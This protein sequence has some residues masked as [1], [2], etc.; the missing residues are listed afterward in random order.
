MDACLGYTAVLGAE[1]FELMGELQ[2]ELR[3]DQ[4][5]RALDG[6]ERMDTKRQLEDSLCDAQ[7]RLL[8]LRLGLILSSFWWRS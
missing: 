8:I 1:I 2:E 4:K 3:D 7:G 5:K 6:W